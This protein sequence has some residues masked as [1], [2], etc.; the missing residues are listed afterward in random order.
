MQNYESITIDL[1]DIVIYFKIF[2]MHL[3]IYL[4][5]LKENRSYKYT[6][7]IH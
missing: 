5:F 3:V 2:Y 7:K 4:K 6:C 1:T